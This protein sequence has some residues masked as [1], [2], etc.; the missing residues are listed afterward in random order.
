MSTDPRQ[1]YDDI[2]D[3]PG[4]DHRAGPVPGRWL[5]PARR[6]YLYLIMLALVPLLVGYGVVTETE[7]ASWLGV[8]GAVL[9]LTTATAN[10]PPEG[11]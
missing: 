2:P 9:G 5:T 10:V 3:Q 4:P 7:A 1:E 11:S 8:A 6:R